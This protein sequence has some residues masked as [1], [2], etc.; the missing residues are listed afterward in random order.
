MALLCLLFSP[1]RPSLADFEFAQTDR[2]MDF[3]GEG[4]VIIAHCL[5]TNL[6]TNSTYG[7]AI[8]LHTGRSASIQD[9]SFY[10][11]SAPRGDDDEPCGY[12]GAIWLDSARAEMVRNC[13]YQCSAGWY[14]KFVHVG[15]GH[16]D[17]SL[18]ARTIAWSTIWQ[19]APPGDPGL[20]SYG[21]QTHIGGS[22]ACD[23][24]ELQLSNTNFTSCH[25]EHG[26]AIRAIGSASLN[27]SF[28]VLLHGN[29]TTGID[30]SC[31]GWANVSYST[32]YQNTFTDGVIY[33]RQ[34]TIW[35]F[36][37]GFYEAYYWPYEL[38]H[39]S[40]HTFKDGFPIAS[41]NCRFSGSYTKYDGRSYS[42]TGNL[43]DQ[44]HTN[45]P[46][47]MSGA[48]HCWVGA[49]TPIFLPSAVI[50]E[51]SN[52]S[53]TSSPFMQTALI[54]S[55]SFSRSA[56]AIET[57]TV[58]VSLQCTASAVWPIS[59]FLAESLQVKT[60]DLLP[61]RFLASVLFPISGVC[62][63]SFTLA[64]SQAVAASVL[65]AASALPEP[66]WGAVN[67]A[68]LDASGCPRPSAG[69]PDSGGLLTVALN[70]SLAIAATA[71][72]LASGDCTATNEWARTGAL[73]ASCPL[74]L[75]AALFSTAAIPMSGGALTG[76][77]LPSAVIAATML[78]V[79]FPAAASIDFDTALIGSFPLHRSRALV[80][81]ATFPPSLAVN[82][83]A[84][85]AV[86]CSLLASASFGHSSLIERTAITHS[87][88]QVLSDSLMSTVS[89][90]AATDPGENAGAGSA[91][92]SASLWIAIAAA[93]VA[94][95]AIA[96]VVALVVWRRRCGSHSPAEQGT[97]TNETFTLGTESI[98][99]MEF[100][101][102]MVSS[103]SGADYLDTALDADEGGLA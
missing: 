78:R 29:G 70:S 72:G 41:N 90:T 84:G 26:F 58:R 44:A 85:T 52:F 76:A 97:A 43:W 42:R 40:T 18:P 62:D 67:T 61:S 75:T 36:D 48:S 60:V 11:C 47:L 73:S 35:L 38:G 24:L 12:G 32:C 39:N 9:C 69:F 53:G 19:C 15:G 94:L 66:S 81:S 51:T 16:T 71:I 96:A 103:D 88:V 5:F 49:L 31:S 25:A 14:G 45:S 4:S 27:A 102:P 79:T 54:P 93:I 82:P 50:H 10:S 56:K 64:V 101:N 87:A 80:R 33:A 74:W 55:R 86:S 6:T 20:A 13:G 8:K 65:L 99:E 21:V 68:G 17:A 3:D 46:G 89:F 92:I 95:L 34:T 57:Q 83:T 7:G 59:T 22:I 77:A 37:C 2:R 30:I 1:V 91:T 28:L 63:G 23:S 100:E 98:G